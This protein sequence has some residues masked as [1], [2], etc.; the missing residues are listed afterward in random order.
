MSGF[1]YAGNILEADLTNS[2][3][4][5]YPSAEYTDIYMGGRGLGAKL[6]WDRVSPK[7][8]AIDPDNCL[9]CTNGPVTGFP[10]LAGSRCAI[11]GKTRIRGED[12]FCY[13]NLG[14]KWG[15]FLKYAGYDGLV[16][17]GKAEKPVYLFIDNESAEIRDA[18]ALW[19]KT[20]F[21]TGDILQSELGRGT[22]VLTIGPAGENLVSFATVVTDDGAVGSGGLGII[23]GA[24][25]LKAVV[26]SG[27]K[28]PR[29]A[30]QDKLADLI[31]PIR[32][33]TAKSPAEKLPW[34]IPGFNKKQICFACGLGCDRRKY[35]GPGGRVYKSVCQASIFYSGMAMSYCRDINKAQQIQR[36]TTR[37]CDS[38]GLDTAVMQPVIEFLEA[39]GKEGILNNAETGLPL[40]KIGS[41][42]FI[43]ELIPKIST[44]NG[45]GKI[46]SLGVL[47]AAESVGKE[48]ESIIGN[49]VATKGGETKDYDPRM[50][51]TTSLLYATEPRRPIQQLHEISRILRLWLNWVNDGEDASITIEEFRHIGESLWGNALAVDFS[52]LEGK[53]MAAKRIQN[54]SYVKE[55]LILCDRSWSDFAR[56][57]VTDNRLI[58]RIYSVITGKE[59]DDSSLMEAGERIFNLQ[60]AILLREGWNGRQG[61]RLLDYYHEKPLKE[62]ELPFNGK[63]LV[64]GKDGEVI[65][66][67]GAVL[68]RNDFEDLKSEY[69]ELRGW[70]VESGLPTKSRLEELGLN[71]VAADLDGRGLLV[72]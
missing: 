3:I 45:F 28:K 53:A 30:D 25:L 34:I 29:A 68:D 38:Y 55:S 2:R 43:E 15:V 21:E 31:R 41:I 50:I 54:R 10:G 48:A 23:M 4:S 60:R 62:G 66:R 14:G 64:P 71:D 63:G 32:E 39:C 20:V 16:V 9:I 61:D 52:T 51:I 58:S 5:S 47:K 37:L 1:G 40:A 13:G 46:L 8:R 72:F 67:I 17:T 26:V 65:S 11:C 18:S 22:S 12:L 44:Q 35:T 27:N 42:E 19:G 24:K 6:Y 69:Y 57:Y 7:T 36:Q 59:V 49:F 56:P 33:M 70:D